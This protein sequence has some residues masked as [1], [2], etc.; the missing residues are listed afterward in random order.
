MTSTCARVYDFPRKRSFIKNWV[1]YV[2]M[3][4]QLRRDWNQSFE[5]QDRLLTRR[6]VR[7]DC[8]RVLRRLIDVQPEH[9]RVSGVMDYIR[10]SNVLYFLRDYLSGALLYLL[11]TWLISGEAGRPVIEVQSAGHYLIWRCFNLCAEIKVFAI[12]ETLS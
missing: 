8:I 9:S 2:H 3:L 6:N 4:N 7:F 11:R 1:Q 12:E 10:N 5:T